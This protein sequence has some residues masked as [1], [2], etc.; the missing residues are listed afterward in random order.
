MPPQP[1]RPLPPR[2]TWLDAWQK[3]SNV[4][5]RVYLLCE[6]G[7]HLRICAGLMRVGSPDRSPSASDCGVRL[8][9]PSS[10]VLNQQSSPLRT[11]FVLSCPASARRAAGAPS[12]CSCA[13]GDPL[14]SAAS[15]RWN[16]GLLPRC[17]VLPANSQSCVSAGA[18]GSCALATTARCSSASW[19]PRGNFGYSGASPW[20][21]VTAPRASGIGPAAAASASTTRAP[22]RIVLAGAPSARSLVMPQPSN[23]TSG[24]NDFFAYEVGKLTYSEFTLRRKGAL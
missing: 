7:V 22:V 12:G 15:Q 1:L 19:R 5:A 17:G 24:R 2:S 3:F 8:L 23:G 9:S 13:D 21:P 18:C 10:A 11:R 4:R 16:S 6:N 20:P 14:R